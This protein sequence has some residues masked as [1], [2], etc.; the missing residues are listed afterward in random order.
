ALAGVPSLPSGRGLF[1]AATAGGVFASS[2][3][4]SFAR[5]FTPPAGAAN[6]QVGFANQLFFYTGDGGFLASSADGR[7][8]TVVPS[9]TTETVF[10]VAFGNALY[11]G[12]G[13]HNTIVTSK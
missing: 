1:A 9:S 12:A 13:D 5:V 11:V 7:A 2:D 6:N 3:G 10:Q 8:W 4:T